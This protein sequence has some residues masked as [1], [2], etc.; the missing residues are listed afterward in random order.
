MKKLLL[1]LPVALVLLSTSIVFA[2]AKE[3]TILRYTLTPELTLPGVCA[4]DLT[5]RST[6]Q[7]TEIDYV[8][9]SGTP[10]RVYIHGTEQD[11]FSGTG[12]SLTTVPYS[13][14]LEL[15]FDS[16]GE[17]TAFVASGLVLKLR[18]PDGGWFLSAGRIN[19]LAHPGIT[20]SVVPDIGHAGN[21]AAFCA[22]LAQP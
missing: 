18:L 16:S 20:F 12:N 10:T 11:T 13:Y 5:I 1:L 8:D 4:F 2:S 14:N 15:R 17:F 6:V 19:V 22:A 9:G 7:V 3:P 21:V